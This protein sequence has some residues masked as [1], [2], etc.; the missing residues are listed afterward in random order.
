MIMPLQ[1]AKVSMYGLGLVETAGCLDRGEGGSRLEALTR[2]NAADSTIDVQ[3]F[4]C[5][6]VAEEAVEEEGQ[7]EGNHDEDHLKTAEITH[8]SKGRKT[9]HTTARH[10]A[11]RICERDVQ[12]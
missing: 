8:C 11:S 6:L 1:V 12:D 7:R 3:R 10:Q 4:R 9:I 2:G 5:G